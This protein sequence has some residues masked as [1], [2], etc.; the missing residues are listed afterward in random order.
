MSRLRIQDEE[1]DDDGG[2]GG[3]GGGEGGRDRDEERDEDE[4]EG[5]EGEDEAKIRRKMLRYVDGRHSFDQIITEQNLTDA[6]ILRKLKSFDP[7]DVAIM[8]R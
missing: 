3:G 2:G 1:D 4:S 6:E 5:E 8:Y 7:G